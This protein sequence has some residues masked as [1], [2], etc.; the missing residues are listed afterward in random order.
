MKRNF[1]L[2]TVMCMLTVAGHSQYWNLTGNA[3]TSPSTNFIGT[4]DA[5]S[6][7]FKANNIF[8]GF[9]DVSNYN[10]AFGYYA[11]AA[12]SSGSGQ[13]NTAFGKSTLQYCTSEQNTAVGWVAL[14]YLTTGVGNTGIGFNALLSTTTAYKNT[15]VGHSALKNVTTGDNNTAVGTSALSGN[16]TGTNNT[17]LGKD[18][19]VNN[20]SY[21]NTTAIGYF[22]TATASNQ[23]RIGNSSVTS[24]GGYVGW[25]NISDGRFKKDIQSNVPGLDFIKLLQPVTYHLDVT[26]I[27]QR[28][29]P[30]AAQANRLPAEEASARKAKEQILF[31]GFVAQDVETAAKKLGYDFNGVDAPKNENDLYS[32]RYADFVVPLVKSVQ[33]L[34]AVNDSLKEQINNLQ[35]QLDKVLQQID[36]LK[37]EQTISGTNDNQAILKQNAPNPFNSTT[38]ISY[39]LPAS[40]KTAQV[41]IS[42]AS[43]QLL[44]NI[45][46]TGRGAGQTT[47]SAGELA[48]GTY[49]YTLYTDG[50]KTDTKQMVLT[51]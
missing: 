33:E 22:A 23:V 9:I 24:I 32:L 14:N 39:Y 51:R 12:N 5:N 16:Y 49:F 43:G 28:L 41:V 8:S 11:L 50:K 25:S 13:G 18:A 15:A 34:S 45:T 48:A 1:S 44:K 37:N 20:T 47:L 31:S 21:S 29:R 2:F 3:G 46:L 42:N 7:V 10:T 35:S 19:D 6:L 27:E 4:T 26:G 36:L 40:C 30:A 17:A 38:V